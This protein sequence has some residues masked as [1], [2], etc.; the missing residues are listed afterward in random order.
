[1]QETRDGDILGRSTEALQR[2][3]AAV[4]LAEENSS[5][6]LSGQQ[7]RTSEHSCS[8]RVHPG[9]TKACFLLN[10]CRIGLKLKHKTELA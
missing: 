2:V 10:S 4:S 9:V 6:Q 3:K 5:E 7:R 8:D 1:M